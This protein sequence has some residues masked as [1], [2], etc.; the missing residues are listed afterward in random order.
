VAPEA[1]R[2]CVELRESGNG[3]GGS[4]LY[5]ITAPAWRGVLGLP[6]DG[7]HASPALQLQAF[8]MLYARFGP[9]AWRPWDGC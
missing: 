8:E 9:S 7:W 4:N 3:A 5:G 6:G 1:F 2:A